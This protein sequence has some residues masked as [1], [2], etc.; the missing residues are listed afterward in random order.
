[1]D[2][3]FS[4]EIE[5]NKQLKPGAAVPQSVN[6]HRSDGDSTSL[7]GQPRV[8]LN[9]SIELEQY[10]DEEHSTTGLDKLAPKLWL[11]S[12]R[13]ELNRSS[14]KTPS[15]SSGTKHHRHREPPASSR[16]VL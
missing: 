2:V 4:S 14:K 10:L 12:M 11:V 16:L 3:P 9:E 8:A 15:S 1:M 7:P 13:I 5:L 6:S